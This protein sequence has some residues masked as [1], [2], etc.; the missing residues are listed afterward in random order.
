[1]INII[2]WDELEKEDQDL[3]YNFPNHHKWDYDGNPVKDNVIIMQQLNVKEI[4]FMM[5]HILKDYRKATI[6]PA[7]RIIDVVNIILHHTI[8]DQDNFKKQMQKIIDLQVFN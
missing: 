3:Y 6:F 2:K 5:E 1:M 4:I 8:P 7:V